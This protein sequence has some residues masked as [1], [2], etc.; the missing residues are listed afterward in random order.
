[1][2]LGKAHMGKIPQP[3]YEVYTVYLSLPPSSKTPKMGQKVADKFSYIRARELIH[4]EII[5]GNNQIT[6][7]KI[8][9]KCSTVIRN[10]QIWKYF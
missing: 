2:S 9:L 3:V 8:L 1:M 6:V 7:S 5:S 10:M 4:M